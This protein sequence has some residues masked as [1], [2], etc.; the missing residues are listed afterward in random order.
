[1][2]FSDQKLISLLKNAPSLTAIKIFYFIAHNQP[3]DG[4][5]GFNTTK[6]QLAIDLNLKLP[7]IFKAL[8]WLK[9]ESFIQELKQ[10]NFSDF[11][12]N[13]YFVMNN[14]NRDERIKEWNRRCRLDNLKIIANRKA[15]RAKKDSLIN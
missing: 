15:K 8:H 5:K 10:V 6:K 4:I 12:A 7:T 3:Q 2:I 14:S 13:P 1:M 11:M 9:E